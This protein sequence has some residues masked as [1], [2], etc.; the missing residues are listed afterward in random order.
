MFYIIFINSTP[1]PCMKCLFLSA[2]PPQHKNL[3][4][5][6]PFVAG[7]N[8]NINYPPFFK[9]SPFLFYT[10]PSN[11]QIKINKNRLTSYF[12]ARFI[13]WFISLYIKSHISLPH[14]KSSSF[15]KFLFHDS[16]LKGRG[17]G[18]LNVWGNAK[19]VFF[20]IM[21]SSLNHVYVM[22]K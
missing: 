21:T 11:F 19:E 20:W 6:V 2:L 14:L 17:G 3:N 7:N 22:F 1:I 15:L 8:N 5:F 13:S 10:Y 16:T 18:I 9:S 12:V 4:S